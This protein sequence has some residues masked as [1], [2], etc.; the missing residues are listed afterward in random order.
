MERELFKN[1]TFLMLFIVIFAV[2][3]I[4]LRNKGEINTKKESGIGMEDLEIPFYIYDSKA[5]RKMWQVCYKGEAEL[6]TSIK[7][8]NSLKYH[9]WRTLDPHKAALFIIPLA[10]MTN[11]LSYGFGKEFECEEFNDLIFPIIDEI[12]H[13]YFF[14]R[15]NGKIKIKINKNK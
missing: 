8:V 4:V 7:F 2:F 9:R 11:S 15:M 12:K 6:R 10:F 3:I 1:K 13:S 5:I 14:R